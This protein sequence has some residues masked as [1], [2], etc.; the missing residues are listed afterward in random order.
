MKFV[1]QL[2][3]MAPVFAIAMTLWAMSYHSNGDASFFYGLVGTLVS[4]FLSVL[5]ITASENL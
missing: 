5:T 1:K 2:I 3:L 4:G